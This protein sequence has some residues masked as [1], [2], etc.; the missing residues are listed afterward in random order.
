MSDQVLKL[1]PKDK[2]FVPEINSAEKARELLEVFFPDGE[3]AEVEFSDSV[4]FIDSGS[5]LEKIT[6]SLCCK[7][8]EINPFQENDIGAEWWYELDETLSSSPDLQTLNV[9][10]PCCGKYAAI[11]SVDFC[12]S[13]SFSMFELCIW[14]PYSDDGISKV[15]L[16]EL[17]GILGCELKQIWAC[18]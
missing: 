16:S 9:K 8:M 17:E 10:M 6:C 18:Y 15:Q 1:V 5:N 14:N 3:Q 2:Y 4:K 11:Q 12:G 13:A 7:S